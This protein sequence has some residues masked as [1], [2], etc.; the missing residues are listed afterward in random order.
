MRLWFSYDLQAVTLLLDRSAFVYISTQSPITP[1]SNFV[2]Y[3]RFVSASL[4]A[5]LT[6]Q[7]HRW[8]L[9]G[10]PN[11]ITVALLP[12]R[13]RVCWIKSRAVELVR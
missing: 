1:V 11:E 4:N 3:I 6:F 13:G 9:P 2:T 10:T 7:L 5:N 12:S 8:F